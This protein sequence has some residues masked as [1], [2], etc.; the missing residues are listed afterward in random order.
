MLKLENVT[1]RYGHKDGIHNINL[2]LE[3]SLIYALIGPNGSGKTTLLESV[4]GLNC[5]ES[6]KIELN[7]ENTRARKSKSKI[8][9]AVDTQNSYPNKTIAELMDMVREIKFTGKFY[10]HQVEL[11]KSFDL[12]EYRNQ[13]YKECSLGMKKKLGIAIS[14]LGNPPLIL[15]D[16]PTNGVDTN[17]IL[18][19]KKYLYDAKNRNCIVLLT[20]H[21]LD[22]V[23]SISD[24]NIF[25][26]NGS[27]EQFVKNDGELEQIY[28]QIYLDKDV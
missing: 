2:V 27:I 17:G 8:G 25:I 21:V 19:L 9:F 28:R 18:T 1:K 5:I 7:G 20:S 11:L 3:E 22:F 12:W 15:L 13:L 6:G 10:E 23:S 14:F 26:K 4:V 16:E 24:Y